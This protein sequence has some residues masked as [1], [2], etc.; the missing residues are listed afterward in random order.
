MPP[1]KRVRYNTQT[2][3]TAL[4]PPPPPPIPTGHHRVSTNTSAFS[5]TATSKAS[6]PQR[7]AAKQLQALHRLH[8]QANHIQS[9]LPPG[10]PTSH[11]TLQPQHQ[12][13]LTPPLTHITRAS[14]TPPSNQPCSAQHQPPAS[15][16]SVQDGVPIVHA[17]FTGP[18]FPSSTL[19]P[20]STTAPSHFN[21]TAASATP[22][23]LP[24]D[25][26]NTAQSKYQRVQKRKLMNTSGPAL[27]HPAASLLQ[28]YADQGCPAPVQDPFTLDALEAAIK[29]GAHTS[30]Q[31]PEAA[32]ALKKEV[33][34]KVAQGYARLIPWDEL[35][36]SLPPNI[37]IS[38]I[39]AIPHKS[40]AFRMILDLSY[41]F[42]L[43]GIPWSSVNTASTP[44]D[45]PLQS[46]TQLGQVLPRLIHRM[47]TSS[48]DEG[49]WV[50]MKLDIKDGF[51]RMMVPEQYEY[52][53]CYVL[54]QD[55][56]TDP[57]QI[58]VP[59]SLQMGWK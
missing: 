49:P 55:N 21:N 13:H 47:A 39:A 2:P 56:P 52:N 4:T 45:P 44:S 20:P 46:M 23:N 12:T 29:R 59:S 38:P 22:I 43:D 54:P 24:P 11:S 57:I 27:Q 50:F 5:P 30:A 26:L 53:F 36:K 37:R 25:G 16:T 8:K 42:T 48:E 58:V 6:V 31:A 15:H 19:V 3:S 1:A 14:L 33:T 7:A 9:Q 18:S 40:R 34:E 17:T 41:M 10:P 28:E 35:K 32:A 51:W